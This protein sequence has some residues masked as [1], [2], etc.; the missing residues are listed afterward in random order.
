MHLSSG[1]VGVIPALIP[2]PTDTQSFTYYAG[3]S[4]TSCNSVLAL[5]Q[6][7]SDQD[8]IADGAWIPL[9]FSRVSNGASYVLTHFLVALDPANDSL[10]TDAAP[11][12][13][14]YD[15]DPT[16][17]LPAGPPLA[18]SVPPF[19]I[20][21]ESACGANVTSLTSASP[22]VIFADR[23]YWILLY[24]NGS[25]LLPAQCPQGQ[26]PLYLYTGADN[27]DL[28]SGLPNLFSKPA[29]CVAGVALQLAV[30]AWSFALFVESH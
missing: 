18:S 23:L 13:H 29:Q 20:V 6:P 7:T 19:E 9:Q 5:G 14:L 25:A 30:G 4:P 21:G 11:S 15:S 8:V 24:I 16:T 3:A 22:R 2:L 27:P 26:M 12:L 10:L 28:V 17:L 1:V